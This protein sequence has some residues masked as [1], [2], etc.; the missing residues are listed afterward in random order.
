[1]KLSVISGDGAGRLDFVDLVLSAFAF[2]PRLGFVVARRE[3][4]FVRF[5][6]DNVFVNVYHG[7]ASYQVGLELGRIRESDIYSLHELLSATAPADTEQARCQTTDPQVL[8]R[9]LSS[10][11]MT[12]QQ[13]CDLLLKGDT[14]AFEKLDAAVAPGRRAVTLQAQFGAVIDRADKA[15]ESKD[16]SKATALYERSQPALDETRMRRLEYLKKHERK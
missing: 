1:M 13:R 2:L 3:G 5:E 10:I 16:F 8:G 6:N 4:T 12:I 15:W 9:C 11:A 7:R 14:D